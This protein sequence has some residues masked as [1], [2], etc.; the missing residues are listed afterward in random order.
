MSL[1]PSADPPGEDVAARHLALL[2]GMNLIWGFNL[3]ASKI[4]VGQFPPI[5]F[6]AMRFAGLGLCLLPWLKLHRG[7]MRNLL[8]AA[9]LT[10]PLSFALLFTGIARVHDVSTVAVASQ[11]GVPFQTLLS[12]W[13]L[14]E[15]IHW[16]RKLGIALAF[17]GVGVISFD[18]RVFRNW[19]GLTFVAASAFLGALGVIFIKNLRAVKPLELQAWVAASGGVVLLAMSLL[20][21]SGQGAALHH[22][23]WLG[24]GALAYT[25]VMASLFAHT[26]WYYLVARYPVTRLAAL[27]LLTPLFGIFFGATLLGDQ[28][29]GRMITGSAITLAGVYVVIRRER[30]IFDT[31]T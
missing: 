1:P 23:G 22:A 9:L 14:G 18:P 6:T 25:A 24:W 3:I 7:E 29:T 12:V 10:G 11:L 2:V 27:T 31:G 26:S 5:F 17:A 28:L 15:R 21:E 19:E 20:V 16:R 8:S 4:G 13:L 30:R